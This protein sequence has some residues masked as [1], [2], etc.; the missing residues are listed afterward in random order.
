[1]RRLKFTIQANKSVEKLIARSPEMAR[2]IGN[3]IEK[4]REN[5]T[6]GN[7]TKIVGF[8]CYRSRVGDYRIIYEFDDELL[9]IT[10]VEKRDKVYQR[11]KKLY[12]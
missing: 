9:Y 6:S 12:F 3:R 2:R 4:L 11:V 10:I 1:M 7:S 5:P 8:P